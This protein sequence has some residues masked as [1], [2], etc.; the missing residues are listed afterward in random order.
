MENSTS[1]H[2]YNSCMFLTTFIIY[3]CDSRRQFEC[4]GVFRNRFIP[5]ASSLSLCCQEFFFRQHTY[6]RIRQI[7][8][9]SIQF[10][11][12]TDSFCVQIT[13]VFSRIDIGYQIMSRIIIITVISKPICVHYFFNI[14]STECFSPSW[15]SVAIKQSLSET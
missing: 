11:H 7:I 10:F 2:R 1:R 9:I 12:Q 6:G 13:A 14:D 3:K 8:Y 5:C 15:S 4:C